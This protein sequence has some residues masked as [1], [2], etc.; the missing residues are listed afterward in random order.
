MFCTTINTWYTKEEHPWG[1]E[2]LPL[3][4]DSFNLMK[5]GQVLDIGAG[6]GG[7]AIFLAKRGFTVT[8][9]DILKSAT[10]RLGEHALQAGISD[11][12]I[13]VTADIADFTWDK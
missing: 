3:V 5:P 13:P 1:T 8:G 4:R 12:V 2:P 6:D 9:I 11:T 7:N 10:K